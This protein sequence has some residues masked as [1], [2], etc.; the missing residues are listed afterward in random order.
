[1]PNWSLGIGLKE[2]RGKGIESF[3]ICM[4]LDGWV[5]IALTL[6]KRLPDKRDRPIVNI[7]L[8]SNRIF[9]L[10]DFWENKRCKEIQHLLFSFCYWHLQSHQ[11]ILT[12]ILWCRIGWEVGIHIHQPVVFIC[13]DLNLG[14]RSPCTIH[15]SFMIPCFSA[16][17]W[18]SQ[19]HSAILLLT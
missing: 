16:T 5:N 10:A 17:C 11:V 18:F 14:L 4:S 9:L 1:M 15:V 2:V 3:W 12:T 6:I 13:E 8:W 19:I 7:V